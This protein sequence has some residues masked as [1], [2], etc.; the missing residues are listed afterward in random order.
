MRPRTTIIQA[1]GVRK[2]A[3]RLRKPR[4]VIPEPSDEPRYLAQESCKHVC[5]RTTPCLPQGNG[6]MAASGH[7]S[8]G[9]HVRLPPD[10]QTCASH[11]ACCDSE[12]VSSD[13][14]AT[15][16]VERTHP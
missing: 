10:R 9:I 7:S 14:A 8:S 13:S 1:F 15:R 2:R 16:V 4:Q 12:Y 11:R 3:L 5:A 6:V